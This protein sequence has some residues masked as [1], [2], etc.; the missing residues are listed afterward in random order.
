MTSIAFEKWQALGNDYLIFE[1]RALPFHLTPARIRRI[2]DPHLGVGADGILLF[3]PT[4]AG[5][6][7]RLRPARRRPRA[8]R[9]ASTSCCAATSTR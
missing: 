1:Q 2:C 3:E 8:S 4:E 6:V 9:W 5:F 7:A